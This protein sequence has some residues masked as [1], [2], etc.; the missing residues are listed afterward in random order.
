MASR[1]PGGH[2]AEG[3]KA[4]QGSRYGAKAARALSPQQLTSKAKRHSC[5]SCSQTTPSSST[6]L[7]R[8]AL[9]PAACPALTHTGYIPS[10]NLSIPYQ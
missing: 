9:G 3:L 6:G 10:F 8:G 1:W 2:L 7:K 5:G 4:T